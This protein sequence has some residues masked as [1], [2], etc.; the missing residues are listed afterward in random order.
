VLNA[1]TPFWPVDGILILCLELTTLVACGLA[2]VITAHPGIF[3]WRNIM[4]LYTLANV[5]SAFGR[6]HLITLVVCIFLII[7]SAI[8]I[9][10]SDIK[11][12]HII[13]IMLILWVL[14]ETIKITTSMK[15]LLSDGSSIEIIKYKAQEG[16]T[17]LRAF[18]PRGDLPFHMCSIQPILILIVKFTTNLKLKDTILKFMFPT[19]ILG[20]FIAIIVDTAGCDFRDIVI[21]EY[22]LFHTALVIFGLS[23]IIKKQITITL[24]SHLQTLAILIIIFVGSIWINAALSDTSSNPVLMGVADTELYTNF[25][26]SM[27]PPMEGLPLLN[28][29]HGWF[30]YFLTIVLI[31][32][33]AVTLIH[34]PF[35]IKEKKINKEK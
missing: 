5:T 15:Y 32:F 19:C 17:I 30:V 11:F 6:N 18:L 29:N 13:N 24:K 8:A 7:I 16:I 33:V 31:G 10:K 21:Y 12:D 20:A 25:F 23:I 2:W 1:S 4:N 35:I 27:Q 28:L 22:F 34:L 3:Y 14:S 26:Y 9:A